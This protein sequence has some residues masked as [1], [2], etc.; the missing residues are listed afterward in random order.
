MLKI[1]FNTENMDKCLCQDCPVQ[2]GSNCV[3]DEIRKIEEIQS[4]DVDAGVM[5]E[6]EEVPKLYCATGK[7]NCKDLYTHEECQCPN[8]DV[9]KENDLEVRGA[10]AYFCINGRAVECCK[11]VTDDEEHKAK[12]R[13]LRRTYYTPI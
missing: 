13:G 3:K 7:T 1:D 11:I 6:P 12:L 4:E 2:I 10:P 5:I 9:W 8:C